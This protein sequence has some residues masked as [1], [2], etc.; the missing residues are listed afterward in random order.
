MRVR[1]GV[2]E[3]KDETPPSPQFWGN[4]NY[5]KSPRIGGF[6]GLLGLQRLTIHPFNQQRPWKVGGDVGN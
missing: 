4:Q 2:A 1:D 5:S 3:A 6:R